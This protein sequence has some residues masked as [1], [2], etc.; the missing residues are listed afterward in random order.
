MH[1]FNISIQSTSAAFFYFTKTC[2]SVSLHLN[3]Y[4]N[5]FYVINWLLLPYKSSKIL[6]GF[7]VFVVSY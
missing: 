5:M 4:D 2:L 1:F 3:K 7:Q 6:Q